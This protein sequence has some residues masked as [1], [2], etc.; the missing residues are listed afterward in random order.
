[1]N[2]LEI[3]L[4]LW[5]V[6]DDKGF[7]YSL[8]ARAYIM[9]GTDDEKLKYLKQ[10][11]LKDYLIASVFPVPDNIKSYL[12]TDEDTYSFP[13]VH[14][15]SLKVIYGS[16]L[17][18]FFE[19]AIKKLESELPVQ[20]KLNIPQEPLAVITPLLGDDNGNIKPAFTWSK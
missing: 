15:S 10:H 20:T 8:R 5:Y 13:V 6:Y 7:I 1:M 11:A 18:P 19:D 9:P 12:H 17:I 16:N 3:I 14:S 4:N 2:D